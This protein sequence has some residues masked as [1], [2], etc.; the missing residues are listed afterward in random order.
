MICIIALIVFAVL[1]VFSARYRTIAREAFDCV[2]RRVTLRKCTS[3]LD[4]RLKSQITGKLMRRSPRAG[5]IVFRNFEVISWIF[6][7]ALILSLGYSAYSV[8]N[9]FVFGN[10][11]G[12]I[13]DAFCA[14][15]PFI[16]GGE[17][18]ASCSGAG[19]ST[20]ITGVLEV[21]GDDPSIGPKDAKVTITEAGCF[22]CPFTRQAVPVVRKILD[23]YGDRIRFVYKDFPMSSLHPG[24]DLA[25]EAAHCAGEQGKYWEYQDIL[26]ENLGM[27]SFEELTEFA[28]EMELD[29][30][31][32]RECLSSGK[33]KSKVDSDF[34]EAFEIGVYGTPTF[35]INDRVVVGP[36]SF[37]EFRQII[38]S[39]LAEGE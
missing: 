3:G 13:P 39:E 29:S 27:N 26:F 21:H 11:N 5:R 12:P 2:F 36:K 7:V 24:S 15:D 34:R 38:D 6:T 19:V 30:S 23:H 18:T 35:F 4:K 33:F 37:N 9:L 22:G 14:F 25:A 16:S 31:R 17:E 1:G 10:C 32:F 28:K 8:Y 20:E